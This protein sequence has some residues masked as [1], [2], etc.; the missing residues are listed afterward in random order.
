MF[1]P[2][3]Q[4]MWKQILMYIIYLLM[5]HQDVEHKYYI[6]QS[7]NVFIYY[8]WRQ[9]SGSTTSA[10]RTRPAPS[11]GWT[12]SRTASLMPELSSEPEHEVIPSCHEHERWHQVVESRDVTTAELCFQKALI[13]GP[14]CLVVEEEQWSTCQPSWLCR[15]A[16]AGS[17]WTHSSL[18]SAPCAGPPTRTNWR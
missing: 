18:L 9:A 14:Q 15:S 6:S 12:R 8:S 16:S 13:M 1:A 5:M 4:L 10:P 7:W 17:G 11:C 3:L 2:H